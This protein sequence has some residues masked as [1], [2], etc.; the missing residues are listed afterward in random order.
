[1]I[2]IIKDYICGS[3]RTDLCASVMQEIMSIT[4]EKALD[5]LFSM[6]KNKAL[7]LDSSSSLRF[8]LAMDNRIYSLTG[9]ESLRYGNGIHTK[10]R[11]IKYH[12]FFIN[13]IEPASRVLDVGCGNGTL[14]HDMAM[15][16]SRISIFAID[17][18]PENIKT[19]L[20]LYARVNIKFIC[21]DALKD[22]PEEKFDVVVLSNILEH[23]D[24]R[25][26]F[27]R[28]LLIRYRPRKILIRI[29]IYERDWRV[30]LKE[31]LGIDYRLDLT[32]CIEYRQEEFFKEMQQAGLEVIDYKIGW[33]EIWAVA[34]RKESSNG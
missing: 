25:Q 27:L 21:G 19:A 26:E 18:N 31:E 5:V 6:I 12:D 30:P 14:A 20:K 9:Q 28:G 32:H 23:L 3:N 16:I 34:V 24:T 4:P 8:L 17:L 22:L 2:K 7:S 10:H 33:G 13:N 11:H 1:M 15:S 29:P